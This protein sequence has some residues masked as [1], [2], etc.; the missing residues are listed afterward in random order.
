MR[1]SDLLHRRVVAEDG[2]A[3]GHVIGLRAVADGPPS[4]PNAL[5]RIDALMVSRRHVG[6]WLGYQNR[7]QQGPWVLAAVVRWLHRSDLVIDWV[8]VLDWREG[9]DVTVR[10]RTGAPGRD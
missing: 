7:E 8:D 3:V 5:L 9:E 1:A 10:T 2:Q 6:S 4:G